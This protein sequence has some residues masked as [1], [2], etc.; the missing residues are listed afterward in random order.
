M[1]LPQLDKSY[2]KFESQNDYKKIQGIDVEL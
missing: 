2:L 1:K